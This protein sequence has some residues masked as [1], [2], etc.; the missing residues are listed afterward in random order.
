RITYWDGSFGLMVTARGHKSFVVQYRAGRQS[1]RMS[2]KAG[3]TLQQARREAKSILGAVAR[4]G[5]PLTD[6]RKVAAS[7]ATTLKAVAEKY[8]KREGGKLRTV[9]QRERA[10]ERLVYPAFGNRQIDSIKRSEIVRLLDGIEEENGPH[11]AQKV[12]SI[13]SK[14]FNWHAGRDDD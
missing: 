13:L 1:R 2:L 7:A 3:L 14:L 10:F 12:F 9:N 5:D 11:M 4:G 8:L 6:K